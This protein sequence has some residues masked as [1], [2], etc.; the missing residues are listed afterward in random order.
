[1]KCKCPIN[2]KRENRL[3]EQV[4]I[5]LFLLITLS[6]CL[7][8]KFEEKAPSV[9]ATNMNELI[10][11][12]NFNWTTSQQVEVSIIGL[13]TAIPINNTQK[14]AGKN[15]SFYTG[16]QLMSTN[17]TLV[18]SVPTS[19]KELTLSYG[20]IILK[21]TITNGKASFSLIPSYVEPTL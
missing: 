20:T 21:S 10:A 18:L 5:L 9:G 19:E 11:P 6:S 13:P 7:T 12:T 4:S 14:I 8:S 3:F 16:R 1:M 15:N 2:M 17:H